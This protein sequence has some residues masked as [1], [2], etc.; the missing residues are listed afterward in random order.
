MGL[1][2]LM[3]RKCDSRR[4]LEQPLRAALGLRWPSSWPGQFVVVVVARA[5]VLLPT[6]PDLA[7]IALSL[8][9]SNSHSSSRPSHPAH[10]SD[11]CKQMSGEQ[12]R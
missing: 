1:C 9:K 10:A 12:M 2:W 3:F 8:S 5:A 11:F 7:R 6:S 4:P